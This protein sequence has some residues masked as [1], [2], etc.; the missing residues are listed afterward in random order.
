MSIRGRTVLGAL[1]LFG[2]LLLAFGAGITKS[3]ARIQYEI[4][5]ER[6]RPD[7]RVPDNTVANL[8]LV[9][10]LAVAAAGPF[11]IFSAFRDMGRQIGEAQTRSESQMRM[12]VTVKRETKPKP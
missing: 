9:V 7:P 8:V 1:L 4:D 12:E 11:V 6:H 3:D 2:G 10:A 5:L